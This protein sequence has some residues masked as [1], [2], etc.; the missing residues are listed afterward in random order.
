MNIMYDIIFVIH[1]LYSCGIK[2]YIIIQK[3]ILHL[4]IMETIQK[5]LFNEIINQYIIPR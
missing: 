2:L 1:P 3:Y 4:N 5:N